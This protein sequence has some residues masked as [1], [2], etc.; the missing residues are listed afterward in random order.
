[1]VLS[2]KYDEGFPTDLLSSEYTNSSSV[3]VPVAGRVFE[4]FRSFF[5]CSVRFLLGIVKVFL[6]CKLCITVPLATIFLAEDCNQFLGIFQ[7][8]ATYL[9]KSATHFFSLT[10]PLLSPNVLP[11]LF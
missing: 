11:V 10:T 6:R 8:T 1:M 3:L 4:A 7:S 9:T 2:L 5:N